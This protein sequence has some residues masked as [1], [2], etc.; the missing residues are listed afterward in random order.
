MG[1]DGRKNNSN[2]DGND[3]DGKTDAVSFSVLQH[4]IVSLQV[5]LHHTKEEHQEEM[6]ELK[7]QLYQFQ[8]EKD[9]FVQELE[10]SIAREQHVLKKVHSL[11]E[12]VYTLR[13]QNNELTEQLERVQ[14]K[15]QE[16]DGEDEVLNTNITIKSG[17]RPSCR[18]NIG[19]AASTSRESTAGITGSVV[20]WNSQQP[21][22]QV[23]KKCRQRRRQTEVRREEEVEFNEFSALYDAMK[24]EHGQEAYA[25]MMLLNDR[26]RQL[27]ME[28][29]RLQEIAVAASSSTST[30]VSSSVDGN[31][32]VSGGAGNYNKE[33]SSN[34]SS[35]CSSYFQ[36]LEQVREDYSTTAKQKLQQRRSHPTDSIR[37]DPRIDL[38]GRVTNMLHFP[39]LGALYSDIDDNNDAS[40]G[41]EMTATA[42]TI[43]IETTGA[44][45]TG[46]GKNN[47]E[48]QSEMLLSQLQQNRN[49][50]L[51]DE[52]RDFNNNRNR[53]RRMVEPKTSTPKKQ[54][55]TAEVQAMFLKDAMMDRQQKQKLFQRQ[56][57]QQ[58]Q[59]QG[60]NPPSWIFNTIVSNL[61]GKQDNSSNNNTRNNSPRNGGTDD[62]NDNNDVDEKYSIGK[63]GKFNDH[64]H[65]DYNKLRRLHDDLCA[66]KQALEVYH[67]VDNSDYESSLIQRHQ[68]QQEQRQEQRHSAMDRHDIGFTSIS[69]TDEFLYP[70]TNTEMDLKETLDLV[71]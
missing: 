70:R 71:S 45:S 62:D 18:S 2:E 56:Q 8:Q 57:Q 3:D 29:K 30:T 22:P 43:N 55:S 52:D 46:D 42:V 26:I 20:S 66:A 51:V 25:M 12:E 50:E 31:S 67:S 14:S 24:G 13:L 9:M 16:D 23:Q 11:K 6:Q 69:A 36:Q 32:I 15:E 58:K 27:Q 63:G 44:A 60:D 19:T 17:N 47:R 54:H 10:N 41:T 61:Q 37:D 65:I 34:A 64:N 39:S 7:S 4:K 5:Q 35:T 40:S 68:Q 59:Q 33:R 1:G 21:Q 28:N 38:S 53:S 48:Q 49:D